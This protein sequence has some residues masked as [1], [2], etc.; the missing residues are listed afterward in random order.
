MLKIN[1]K[2]G[3]TSFCMGRSIGP[4]VPYLTHSFLVGDILIDTGTIY[5]KDEFIRA[6]GIR[7]ISKVINTHHHEDHT[8]NNKSVQDRFNANIYAHIQTLPY[9]EKPS[10]IH[11]KPY[12]KIVWNRPEASIGQPLGDTVSSNG[13]TFDV[14]HTPGHCHDHICL[15]EP[16]K[17]WLFSGDIFCGKRIRYMRRDENFHQI[18]SSLKSLSSLDI[19]IICCGL[20]GIIENNGNILIKKKIDF[21]EHLRKMVMDLHNQGKSNKYIKRK[22]LGRE[23]HMSILTNGHFSKQNI[24]DSI[25]QERK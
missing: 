7:S 16:S 13:Y 9:L 1:Q 23:D 14:I 6:L 22:V 24:I 25:L 5:A 8:G 3:I 10:S 19:S 20:K 2:E 4:I 18:L 17:K 12:Q 15:Y 21:M 11:M